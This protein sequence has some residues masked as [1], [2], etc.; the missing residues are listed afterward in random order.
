MS[1][2]IPS[3]AG[4]KR[5]C[6]CDIPPV[7]RATRPARLPQGGSVSVYRLRGSADDGG[8]DVRTRGGTGGTSFHLLAGAR[9]PQKVGLAAFSPRSSTSPR[10]LPGH[11]CADCCSAHWHRRRFRRCIPPTQR[12]AAQH[13]FATPLGVLGIGSAAAQLAKERDEDQAGLVAEVAN[14]IVGNITAPDRITVREALT[15]L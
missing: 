3:Q 15:Y 13:R 14:E 1:R 9:T 12:G 5:C 11:P 7:S 2:C 6:R 4:T 8:L 10:V